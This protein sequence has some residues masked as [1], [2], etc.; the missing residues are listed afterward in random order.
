M[1]SKWLTAKEIADI[2]GKDKRVVNRDADDGN[3]HFRTEKGNGGPHKSYQ[4]ISLPE[5]V[6][7]AYAASRSITL[8]ELHKQL[9]PSGGYTKKANIAGYNGRG[10]KTK[11][12]RPLGQT[13]D[14]ALKIASLRLKLIEAYSRSGLSANDFITAYE[15]GVAVPDL[16]EELGRWGNIHTPSNFYKNWLRAYEEHGLAGL[17][18]QYAAS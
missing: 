8:E 9:R 17:A 10:A 11:E 13:T 15:N 3:W 16:K 6:Q 4:V 5:D 14:E 2:L 12:A 18:P 1:I 7:T